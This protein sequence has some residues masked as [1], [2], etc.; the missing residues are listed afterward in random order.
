MNQIPV[1]S[2]LRHVKPVESLLANA[3]AEVLKSGYFV[4]GPSVSAFERE[5]ADYCGTAFCVSVANGTDA[6]EISLR[7]LG[8]SEGDKVA[9]CANAAMYGT[10]AVMACGAIP[11]FVD[12]D[13]SY[14]LMDVNQLTAICASD[15]KPIAVI[16]THLYGRLGNVE[17]VSAICREN[18]ILLV[19]DCAQAHGAQLEDG[20]KAGSFGDAAAFSFYPT[21]NLGA[22]GD[23]GAIIT[24]SVDTAERARKL[25]QYGWTSKYS[26]GIAGGRNSRLDEIQ[27]KMLTV[28]LPMLDGWNDRRREIANRYSVEIQN[29]ALQLPPVSGRE[30]VAHLYV[31]QC[32]QRDRMRSHLAAAGI[33]TDVHYPIPDH[34]QQ[35]HAGRFE[36]V[37]LP[38]AEELSKTVLTLP[39]FPELT[40]AEVQQVVDACNAF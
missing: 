2:L 14:G 35:C 11:V 28:M 7:S 30:Y 9:V 20:R 38:V 34:R 8:I 5:F 3:A 16:L 6:L 36:K 23:G 27:A 12:V 18:G 31:V 40:D 17:A 13:A 4:L 15:Q 26:N 32:R 25:R 10:S 22:V 29:P 37:I 19:E 39:C 33:Q 21:K 24:N 1:N